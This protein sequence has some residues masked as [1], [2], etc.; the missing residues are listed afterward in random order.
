MDWSVDRARH[1]V[2]ID[3]GGVSLGFLNDLTAAPF[4]RQPLDWNPAILQRRISGHTFMGSLG[5][6]MDWH[7]THFLTLVLRY[8]GGFHQKLFLLFFQLAVGLGSVRN[9]FANQL[10]G[11]VRRCMSG[12]AKGSY[13]WFRMQ[14]LLHLHPG[15]I[16]L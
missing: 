4:W 14:T 3:V 5:M 13:Q 2:R 8:L 9:A 10:Q 7:A 11:L 12:T 1:G 6:T 15:T 16:T